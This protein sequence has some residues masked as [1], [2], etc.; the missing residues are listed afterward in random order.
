MLAELTDTT[1]MLVDAWRGT[2]RLVVARTSDACAEDVSLATTCTMGARRPMAMGAPVIKGVVIFFDRAIEGAEGRD[3]ALEDAGTRA[4][5]NA[6]IVVC[7]GGT[8]C[9]RVFPG[10]RIAFP[11]LLE[12]PFP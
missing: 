5:G 10:A 9:A 3:D 11:L 2:D 12:V 6:G 1:V 4:D 7:G 8:C